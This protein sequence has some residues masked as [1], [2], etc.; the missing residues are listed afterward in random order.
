MRL[1]GFRG[2]LWDGDFG[3]G[4]E[5]QVMAFQRDFM[6][7]RSPDG[8]ANAAVIDAMQRFA[9]ENPIDFTALKCVC[10]KCGGFGQGRFKG[11]FESGKPQTEAF[12]RYE[13]PGIHKAI[14]HSYRALCFYAKK[15]HQ[16]NPYLTCGYRCWINNEEKQR[17]TTN[18]MGKALDVD[19]P[20]LP[21][22]D[23]RDDCNRCDK[24]RGM[25][26]ELANFQIGW[27]A[28]NF[29]SLEPA[30]IAPSWVHMDVRSYNPS[31]LVDGY[32]VKKPESLDS[33]EVQA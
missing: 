26:V 8:I 30:D 33:L 27:G 11:E 12:H 21:T 4:T 3:P 23:K 31:Y 29:K 19:F 1:A 2:T 16:I 7:V 24:M 10:G 5:L 32:F 14:L 17:T 20:M 13:Y 18:H 22:D 28:A 15:G 6:G 25:L 9:A